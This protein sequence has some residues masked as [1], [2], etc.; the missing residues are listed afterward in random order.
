MCQ[1]E[2]DSTT[3]VSAIMSKK[4]V[5]IAPDDSLQ[6]VRRLFDEHSFHHLIVAEGGKAMGVISHRDL[7]KNLSPFVGTLSEKSRDTW[8]LDKRVH[9]VMS[10]SI[11]W[12]DK[13][14]PITE[15]ALLMAA[16]RISCLPI[17]DQKGRPVGI[18]TTFDVLRWI[19]EILQPELGCQSEAA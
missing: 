10:R 11:V 18:V 2:I 9:Q 4:I 19:A 3:P 13:D 16:N 15:A 12:A 5:T 8:T 1:V 14:T 6:V 7:L 17:L